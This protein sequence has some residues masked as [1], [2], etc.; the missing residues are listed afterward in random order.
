MNLVKK[1]LVVSLAVAISGMAV[2]QGTAPTQVPAVTKPV[3]VVADVQ[4]AEKPEVKAEKVAD[5]QATKAEVKAEKV[6]KKAKKVKKA[7]HHVVK[8]ACKAEKK[9]KKA[10]VKAKATEVPEVKPAPAVAG[11]VDANVNVTAEKSSS[12]AE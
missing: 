6:E 2:A 7:R 12:S 4:S 10:E 8:K 5:T 3:A 9:A 11:A 1:I